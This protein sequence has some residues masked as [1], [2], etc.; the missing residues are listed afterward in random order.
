MS[1]LSWRRAAAAGA[2]GFLVVH[3]ASAAQ[4]QAVV[5]V[6]SPVATMWQAHADVTGRLTAVQGASLAAA[7]PGRVSDVL[8]HS[9]QSVVKGQILVRQDDSTEQAQIGLDQAKLAQ[10][11]R[12]LARQSQLMAI[13]GSSQ[14]AFEA[15]QAA[16]AEA[17]AQL[18]L[19]QAQ[20]AQ[21]LTTAPFAGRVGLRTISPGDYLTQGQKIVDIAELA[22]LHVMFDVPQTEAAGLARGERFD[23][24][25]PAA[26]AGADGSGVISAISPQLDTTIRAL[27]VQGDIA[28]ADQAL[29]P[30]MYVVVT[31]PVGGKIPAWQIPDTALTNGALGSYV[32]VV[33]PGHDGATVVHAVYVHVLSQQPRTAVVTGDLT[34]RDKIVA[35]GGFKLTDGQAVQMQH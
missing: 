19:D 28:N 30:G 12:D 16:V 32:L 4:D 17:R 27:P 26:P 8:F 3:Q 34:A 25:A 14:A 1:I 2:L 21:L 5:S 24:A 13:K 23:I 31:L 6:A 7:Q 20:A 9:G 35:I 15:A 11:K 22:P 18:A 29:I 33:A 10:A